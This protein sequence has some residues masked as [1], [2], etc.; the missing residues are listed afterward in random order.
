MTLTLIL[1]R[2]AKSEW[3][4][5]RLDDHDR[6]L[7][8]RGRDS[9]PAIGAWLKDRRHLPQQALVSTATRAVETWEGMAPH[10]GSCEV[11]FHPR[12]YHPAPDTMLTHL[13]R[14][15]AQTVLMLTHNPGIGA[16]AASLVRDAPDHPRF[17][18]YPTAAT[19][20]VRFDAPAWADIT[21]GTGEVLDFVVPRDLIG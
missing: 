17:A 12:L 2:H 11:S 1:T 21:C 14:A 10:L 6:T 18:D 20:V 16:L 7:N 9:A 13:A 8:A 5:P 4:D 3:D 19:L 15:R